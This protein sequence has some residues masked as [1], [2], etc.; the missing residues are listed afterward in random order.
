MERLL[1][2][3]R[4]NWGRP[5]TF[6]KEFPLEAVA[7]NGQ[8]KQLPDLT[9]FDTGKDL[10]MHIYDKNSQYLGACTS[11]KLGEGSPVHLCNPCFDE[12]IPGVWKVG[13][14]WRWTPEMEFLVKAGYIARESV[15]EAWIWQESHQSLRAWAEQIGRGLKGCGENR[16]ARGMLK[17]IYTMGLGWLDHPPDSD[18]HTSRWYRP[19]WWNLIVSDARSKMLYKIGQLETFG[20]ECVWWDADELGFLSTEPNP[21]LAVPHILNREKELGGFKVKSSFPATG[22]VLHALSDNCSWGQAGLLFDQLEAAAR[23]SERRRQ[24]CAAD[25]RGELPAV[26]LG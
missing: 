10:Y 17:S 16:I 15:S 1:T 20:F 8:K 7:K 5:C 9:R 21:R 4:A 11:V 19:D 18:E 14:K 23:D 25:T 26:M 24:I 3:Q 2:G 22:A 6:P 12:H 13:D